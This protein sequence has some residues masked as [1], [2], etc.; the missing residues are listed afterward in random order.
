[1]NKWDDYFMGT[2]KRTAEL[3]YAS[4][5]KVG[6]VA[7]RNKRIICIGFNGTP[8]ELPN[9]CEKDGVTLPTV[10]HAEENL[11][12][13]AA[14]VGISLQ[15]CSIYIT[16]QPCL[17]CARMVFGAGFREIIYGEAY[18][19]DEGLKFLESVSLNIRKI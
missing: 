17:N 8:P 15:G 3:S 10:L 12:L 18:R 5:L 9:E 7:V 13:Y 11:I 6:A 16:H 2:A 1:M 14:K 19:S 4:R